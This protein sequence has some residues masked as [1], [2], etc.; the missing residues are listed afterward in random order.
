MSDGSEY[1]GEGPGKTLRK[2]TAPGPDRPTKERLEAFA[3]SDT[4]PPM[5]RICCVQ[6]AVAMANP[7]RY[8]VDDSGKARVVAFSSEP[9]KAFAAICD[10]LDGKATQ[11][12]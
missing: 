6:L 1:L 9:G 10:R 8:A 11:Q 5:V 4:C 7:R 2:L 3:Q 12:I